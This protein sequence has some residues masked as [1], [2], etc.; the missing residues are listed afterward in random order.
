M[1]LYAAL[2]YLLKYANIKDFL[3]LLFQAKRL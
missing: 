2:V 3:I 1:K